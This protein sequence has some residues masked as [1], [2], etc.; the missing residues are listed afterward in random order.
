MSEAY[1]Y[2]LETMIPIIPF[3]ILTVWV[4]KDYWDG[5]L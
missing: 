3:V 2:I 4:V 5:K 1:K